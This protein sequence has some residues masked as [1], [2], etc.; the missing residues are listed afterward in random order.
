M[1]QT[2]KVLFVTGA[3]GVL[4]RPAVRGLVDAGHRVRGVARTP[5]KAAEL[6]AAGAE[7]VE[8]DLFDA[9]AV[10]GATAG[11]EAIL[12]LATHIPRLEDMR[13]PDAWRTN[14]RLR[15]EATRYLLDAAHAHGIA[16]FVKE[17]ITF[18]YA[19]GGTRWIDETWEY[20]GARGVMRDT[21]EG[22][23]LVDEFVAAGGH[24]VTLRFGAFLAPDAHHTDAYL[25][26]ARRRIAPGAGRPRS[27]TSSIHSADAASAVVAALDAPAGV[28][29]IVDDEPLTRRD[30]TDA[31]SAAFGLGHLFITPPWLMKLLGR[32]TADY[33]LR[34][35]RVSNRKFREATGWA[36]RHRSAREA[37]AAVAAARPGMQE[38]QRSRARTSG[39]AERSRPEMQETQRSRA[40]TSGTAERSRPGMQEG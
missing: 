34:S 38:T 30:F 1:T 20:G 37:W 5:A 23:R 12:H 18:P 8:V 39:T 10:K 24:G 15:T 28:Y 9:A 29:N 40:R 21:I 7:P 17:S 2:G 3:T 31:F 4:G 11:A 14:A 13:K 26:L 36:P 33:L 35:Q 6:R 19:D 16:T 25:R 27:Y 22:E 32:S